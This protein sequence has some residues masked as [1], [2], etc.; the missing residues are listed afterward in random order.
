M[1]AAAF[2]YIQQMVKQQA[3]IV[4][5]PGK[6]YLAESRL[7]GFSKELGFQTLDLFVDTLRVSPFGESHR[8]VIELLTTNETSF[9]RDIR[10]FE[11]LRTTIIPQLLATRPGRSLVIWC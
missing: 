2:G 3:G 4:V 6:E 5:E 10:P 7:S 9:F 8:R 1:Q 11:A